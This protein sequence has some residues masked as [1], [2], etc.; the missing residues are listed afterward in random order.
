MRFEMVEMSNA[1]PTKRPRE[2]VVMCNVRSA[3]AAGLSGGLFS[4]PSSDC[5][6]AAPWPSCAW[7]FG[8]P[9]PAG[10]AAPS[11][12]ARS[13][14]ALMRTRR[15][16]GPSSFSAQTTRLMGPPSLLAA[17]VCDPVT[18]FVSLSKNRR[19]MTLTNGYKT[20]AISGVGGQLI[21]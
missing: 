1:P 12:R 11:G 5:C 20:M 8:A 21:A 13:M 9:F 16:A 14:L 19:Y 18:N 6:C 7:A 15:G 4:F 17:S 2:E 3:T 10:R